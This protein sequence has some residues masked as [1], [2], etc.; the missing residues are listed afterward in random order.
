MIL[1]DSG[2]W[3]GTESFIGREEIPLSLGRTDPSATN[4]ARESS[5]RRPRIYHWSSARKMVC[6]SAEALRFL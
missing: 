4:A 2:D 5:F 1:R 6:S 3:N